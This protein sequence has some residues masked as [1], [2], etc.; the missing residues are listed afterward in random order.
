[1]HRLDE[2]DHEAQRLFDMVRD[3]RNDDDVVREIAVSLRRAAGDIPQHFV[4]PDCGPH[5]AADGEGE[6]IKCGGGCFVEDC[7]CAAVEAKGGG[8]A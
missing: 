3:G 5:V 6:C 7:T 4:C 2:H 1:M 8:K